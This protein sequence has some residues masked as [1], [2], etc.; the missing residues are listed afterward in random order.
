[1]KKYPQ[2]LK[3]VRGTGL[4]QG[5]EIAGKTVEESGENAYELHK[6]LLPLGVVVGRGSAAGNVFRIQP[7]MCIETKDVNYVVD[8]IAFV[9][10]A[11]I[12]E[13]NL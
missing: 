13:N 7:P 3:E 2:A 12:K 6:R 8:S 1:M 10:D 9:V 4:F 5:L 11:W